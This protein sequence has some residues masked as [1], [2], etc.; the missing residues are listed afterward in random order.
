MTY[1]LDFRPLGPVQRIVG[2]HPSFVFVKNILIVV[3]ELLEGRPE[4]SR[5]GG[6]TFSLQ[7]GII[8]P[9]LPIKRGCPVA[10]WQGVRRGREKW[11]R[12]FQLDLPS[13]AVN[14]ERLQPSHA[15][16]RGS[17]STTGRYCEPNES[18]V[19]QNKKGQ[20][21]LLIYS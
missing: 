12:P 19:G 2:G 21:V 7:E 18:E 16:Q 9:L 13:A 11:V 15:N 3:Q 4:G 20:H 10:P 14:Q 17:I 5:K 6:T 8:N 1:G